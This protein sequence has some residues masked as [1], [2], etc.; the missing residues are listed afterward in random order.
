[1]EA[2]VQLARILDDGD[3]AV[4]KDAA[5]APQLFARAVEE[6]AHAEAMFELGIMHQCGR[7]GFPVDLRRAVDLHSDTARRTGHE[8][9]GLNLAA[10]LAQG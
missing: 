5:R 2:I 3:G 8:M 9:A 4:A 1:M 10:I 6:G 7:G